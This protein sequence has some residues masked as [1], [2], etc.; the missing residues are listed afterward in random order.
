MP[1]HNLDHLIYQDIHDIEDGDIRLLSYAEEGCEDLH[2][3][4]AIAWP[5]N[6]VASSRTQ[7]T[8]EVLNMY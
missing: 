2:F 7:K 8:G 3:L 6:S 4:S 1:A 5:I